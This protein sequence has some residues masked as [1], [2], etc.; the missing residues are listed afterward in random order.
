M[1]YEISDIVGSMEKND[2]WILADCHWIFNRYAY[3]C[4][5]LS[6]PKFS[7]LLGLSRYRSRSVNIDYYVIV[8]NLDLS[9]EYISFNAISDKWTLD[10][11]P[12]RPKTYS[13]DC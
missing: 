9:G 12:M 1:N 6:I 2:V 13:Y 10:W 4:I 3:S 5:Y 8:T 11:R 7:K